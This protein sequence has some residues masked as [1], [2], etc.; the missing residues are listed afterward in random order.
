MIFFCKNSASNGFHVAVSNLDD[1]IRVELH[2]PDEGGKL[3]RVAARDFHYEDWRNL[4]GW[5]DRASWMITSDCVMNG[6]T[7]F[8]LY[9]RSWPFRTSAVETTSTISC[10]TPVVSVLVPT[11]TAPVSRWSYIVFAADRSK[12]VGSF[13]IDEEASSGDEV[14]ERVSPKLVFENFPDALPSNGFVDLSLKLVDFADKPVELDATAEVSATGGVLSCSRPQIKSGRGT[15]RWF[16]AYTSPGDVL[17][18]KVGFKL[19]SGT[20]KRSLKVIEG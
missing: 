16:G 17:D 6:A 4:R 18:V 15:V 8:N 2:L 11:A 12:V 19:F 13:P 1:G 7:P 10:F 14:R 3:N 9:E 20:D 5:S